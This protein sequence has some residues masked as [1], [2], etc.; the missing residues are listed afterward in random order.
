MRCWPLPRA[1]IDWPSA[2][3][4]GRRRPQV[5]PR[6]LAHARARDPIARRPREARVRAPLWL[7]GVN[8]PHPQ[9]T[10]GR[11]APTQAFAAFPHVSV[12]KMNGAV[13]VPSSEAPAGVSGPPSP[14]RSLASTEALGEDEQW[15]GL[16]DIF[17]FEIFAENSLEQ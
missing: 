5:V 16:L 17:G 13:S 4:A 3:R 8:P 11:S 6:G 14:A 12:R 1:F 2:C 10:P 7:A 15:I 9:N